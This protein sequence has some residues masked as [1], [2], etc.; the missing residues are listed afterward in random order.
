VI[1]SFRDQ[2]TDDV[3]YG[4]NTREARRSCPQK[5]WAVAVRKLDQLDSVSSLEDLRIPPG[6][7]LEALSGDRE[8]QY[9]IRINQQYRVCFVWAGSEPAEVEIADYH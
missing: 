6:N 4:R 1:R 2:G 8:G 9:S 3:F 5:L 7:R